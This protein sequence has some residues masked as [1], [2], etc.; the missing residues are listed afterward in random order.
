[1]TYK[2]KH[3]RDTMDTYTESA[4][5]SSAIR[6]YAAFAHAAAEA[7]PELLAIADRITNQSRPTPGKDDK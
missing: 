7:A 6:E 1:M 4:K 2:F 3:L 5:Y